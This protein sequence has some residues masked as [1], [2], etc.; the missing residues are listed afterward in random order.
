M[1]NRIKIA[2]T[3]IALTCTAKVSSNEFNHWYIG[4]LY[5]TQD[6]SNKGFDLSSVGMIT[7]YKINDFFSIEGR[8]NLGVSGYYQHGD[9]LTPSFNKRSG[10]Y[11]GE[12]CYYKHD[13]D[14]QGTILLK[15]SYPI[16]ASNFTVYALVGASYT[17]STI[18][19]EG[20]IFEMNGD[21]FENYSYKNSYDDSGITYGAGIN[22]LLSKKANLFF[23]YQVLSDYESKLISPFDINGQWKSISIGLNYAF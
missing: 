8:F 22:Y 1:N 3:L 2:L 4:G 17:K 21:I 5:T 11:C 9:P 20:S 10:F 18:E 13:I 6:I 15:A 7:G 16:Q 19:A 14:S 23:D 12:S